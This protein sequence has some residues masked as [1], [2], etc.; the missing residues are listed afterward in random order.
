MKQEERERE[1]EREKIAE[2][3]KPT[4]RYV[5]L[6]HGNYSEPEQLCRLLEGN[7]L[8]VHIR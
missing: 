3:G 8:A 5:S 1:R 6:V 7:N 4:V 2:L